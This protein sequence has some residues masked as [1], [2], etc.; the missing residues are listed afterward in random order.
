MGKNETENNLLK[1]H[2]D[3]NNYIMELDDKRGPTLI[4]IGDNPTS[5]ILAAAGGLIQNFTKSKNS[6]PRVI[7]YWQAQSPSEVNS[8]NAKILSQDEI[9][10]M[11][12]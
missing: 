5:D 2:A 6:S 8:I 11:A 4:L 9:E 7:E 3:G 10:S 1:E 12:I